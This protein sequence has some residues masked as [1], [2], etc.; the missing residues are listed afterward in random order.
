MH[1]LIS[2]GPSNVGW[3][4]YEVLEFFFGAAYL[5]HCYGLLTGLFVF[6]SAF[7]QPFISCALVYTTMGAVKVPIILIKYFHTYE[8]TCCMLDTYVYLLI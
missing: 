3:F 1:S 8:K 7:V 6:T 2:H 4:V 5:S